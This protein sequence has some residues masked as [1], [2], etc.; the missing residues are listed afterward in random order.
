[1]KQVIA[2][3]A[4]KFGT[5]TCVFSSKQVLDRPSIENAQSISNHVDLY[6]NRRHYY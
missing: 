3:L 5:I 2:P 4:Q 6:N 1:V